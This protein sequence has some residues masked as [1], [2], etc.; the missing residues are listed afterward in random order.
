VNTY[1]E[2][3][4]NL[5][6]VALV[7]RPRAERKVQAGLSDAGIE[8][9]V[10]W[11]GVRR[12]WSDRIKVLKQNLFP[13]YVFCRSRFADRFLVMRQPGV[14]YVV[15]FNQGPAL[16]PDEEIVALRRAIDSGLPLGPWPFLKAGQRVRVERGLL[17]GLE[18]T[19]VDDSGAW[20]F[21]I[22]INALERSVAIEVDR[23]MICPIKENGGKR[24]AAAQ[25]DIY[26]H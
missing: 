6:W 15:S 24:P 21:A 18:G 7:V 1:V 8:T 12:R 25:A 10:A 17:A 23:D 3:S 16:I 11:H 22:S 26:G 9:F 5:S 13:G 20:R 14:E 19:L 2:P 4:E